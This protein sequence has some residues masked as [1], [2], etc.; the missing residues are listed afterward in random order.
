MSVLAENPVFGVIPQTSMQNKQEDNVENAVFSVIPQT[1]KLSIQNKQET[2]TCCNLS[3]KSK[4]YKNMV[5]ICFSF[6]L[7]FGSFLGILNLQSSINAVQGLGLASNVALYAT[8]MIA[9]IF[10]SPYVDLIGSKL[11]LISGYFI[12]L[13]YT[14]CNYYPSWY[15][16]ISG[17]V[18]LGIFYG[19]VWVAIYAHATVTA[20]TY[21][22][23]L[24]E[25]PK[26]AIALF[27]A[28]VAAATKLSRITGSIVSSIVLF[29]IREFNTT[30]SMEISGSGEFSENDVC[31]NDEASQLEKIF[32]YYILVSLYML[33][34][35][36][37]VII[38]V[39][40]VDHLGTNYLST[41]SKVLPICKD[42]L[43]LPLGRV[44][45]TLANSKMLLLLPLF[46]LN[47]LLLGFASGAFPKVFISDC[48]GVH[49]I[50]FVLAVF[51]L[52]GGIAALAAGR[53]VRYLPQYVMMY[54]A[55]FISCGISL[56][57]IFW[58]RTPNYFAIFGFAVC[59]GAS[60]GI[61]NAI[62][63]GI[64]YGRAVAL[65]VVLYLQY[66]STS[67]RLCRQDMHGTKYF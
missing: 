26:N 54:A 14:A 24:K 10:A 64:V 44:F 40:L 53:L 8:F 21:S 5:G 37:G 55:L 30:L 47:G 22:A 29:N 48:I 3:D 45:K 25:E 52:C 43:L 50:G 58:K 46:I 16:L 1:R 57:F 42:S 9:G 51:G 39:A 28:F 66:K 2:C 11:S 67:Q 36:I 62:L 23:A 6:V 4:A 38:T 20:T 65:G 49:W 31:N 13:V 33:F 34:G 61:I 27:V 41:S 17:S 59:W 19:P 18:L 56:V 32:L 7:C 12:F 15:T 35:I 60:E 63:P